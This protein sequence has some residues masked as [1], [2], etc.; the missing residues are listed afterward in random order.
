HEKAYQAQAR[1]ADRNHRDRSG[2]QSKPIL[3]LLAPAA[4]LQCAQCCSEYSAVRHGLKIPP[5]FRR[6]DFGNMEI[7]MTID[8]PKAYTKPWTG[9]MKVHLLPDTELFETTCENSRS[10]EHMVGK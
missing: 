5:V 8:D 10:T 4:V 3:H 7:A 6:S 9:T 1:D 2:R